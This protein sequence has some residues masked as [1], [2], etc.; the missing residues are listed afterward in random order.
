MSIENSNYFRFAGLVSSTILNFYI[1]LT[2]YDIKVDNSMINT[3][4]RLFDNLTIIMYSVH[5]G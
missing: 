1:A 2:W 5:D 3:L 4:I